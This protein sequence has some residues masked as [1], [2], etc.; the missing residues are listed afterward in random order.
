MIRIESVQYRDG[1]LVVSCSGEYGVGSDGQPSDDLLVDT[2][3]G[4]LADHPEESVR[5]IDVDYSEVEYSWGDG[6][7]SIF[8][9]RVICAAETIRLIA[10]PQNREALRS[11]VGPDGGRVVVVDMSDR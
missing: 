4:W 9:C 2:I 1:V 3:N 7:M 8:F 5:Q 11:L 10:G 6:P